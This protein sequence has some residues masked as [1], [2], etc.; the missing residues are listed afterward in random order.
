M[1]LSLSSH[2]E[3]GD[4]HSYT[5]THPTWLSQNVDPI[6]TVVPSDDR[7][8][9]PPNPSQAASPMMSSLI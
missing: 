6:A 3:A 9:D 4:S 7:D 2:Y 1:D 5:R 8:S